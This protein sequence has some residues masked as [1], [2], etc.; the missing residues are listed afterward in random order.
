MILNSEIFDYTAEI[1]G[2]GTKLPL[3]MLDERRTNVV[4]L[5]MKGGVKLDSIRHRDRL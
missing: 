4:L 3:L 1:C 5:L 2:G